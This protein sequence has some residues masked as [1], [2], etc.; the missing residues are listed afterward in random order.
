MQ[1][2]PG[3]TGALIDR[4]WLPRPAQLLVLVAHPQVPEPVPDL[5]LRGVESDV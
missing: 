3:V 5:V 1:R 4:E 2:E